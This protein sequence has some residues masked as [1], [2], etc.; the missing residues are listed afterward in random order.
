MRCFIALLSERHGSFDGGDD[1]GSRR[2]FFMPTSDVRKLVEGRADCLM[3]PHPTE[4]GD[5][6]NGVLVACSV[7]M[8][9]ENVV[10]NAQRSFKL[11]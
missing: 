2:D 4:M 3:T 1:S 6:R 7:R 11:R 9:L 5:V 10:E 8:T